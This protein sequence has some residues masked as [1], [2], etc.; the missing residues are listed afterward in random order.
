MGE[1]G[2][3]KRKK[4]VPLCQEEETNNWLHY[5]K[6][7]VA[8]PESLTR[9]S[10][11]LTTVVAHHSPQL[12]SK[13]WPQR[14]RPCIHRPLITC[15]T[16]RRDSS[17]LPGCRE[18]TCPCC[19]ERERVRE[20]KTITVDR[21]GVRTKNRA[22][23]GRIEKGLCGS[24]EVGAS[25]NTFGR[26]NMVPAMGVRPASRGM[27]RGPGRSSRWG[28]SGPC[29]MP[30]EDPAN[31]TTDFSVSWDVELLLCRKC[32]HAKTRPQDGGGI[33]K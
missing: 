1:S 7:F 11:V 21:E 6:A 13:L 25:E 23:R 27:G 10:H 30:R 33:S 5:L 28:P 4:K 29:G 8:R 14:S 12:T 2:D 20:E 17:L 24:F 9:P 3:D 16:E 32:H 15:G 19:L 18:E 31:V 22:E 26:A